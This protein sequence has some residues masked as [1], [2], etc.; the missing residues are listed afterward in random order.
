MIYLQQRC[1]EKKDFPDLYDITAAG[2]IK[3]DETVSDA[4]RE[5]H[6]ELG[7][8]VQMEAL[9]PL[10]V[11]RDEIVRGNFIDRERCHVFLCVNPYKMSAFKLQK[12][13]VAGIYK[14]AYPD[15]AALVQGTIQELN[16]AGFDESNGARIWRDQI[17]DREQCVP[18]S[19]NYYNSLINKLSQLPLFQ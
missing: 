15:F 7:V 9:M 14:A 18:H 10:G 17:I 6:E 11:I 19:S 1:H 5:I 12:E 2:H 13:E 16:L 8:P 4:I 3:A